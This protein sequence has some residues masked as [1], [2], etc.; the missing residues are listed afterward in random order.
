VRC[1][2]PTPSPDICLRGLNHYLSTVN[3][4]ELGQQGIRV[5][6]GPLL[7]HGSGSSRA[8]HTSK[9][10]AGSKT[11]QWEFGVGERDEYVLSLGHAGLALNSDDCHT[12]LIWYS[13]ARINA[14]STDTCCGNVGANNLRFRMDWPNKGQLGMEPCAAMAGTCVTSSV[15]S[16][17]L[18]LSKCQAN[19]AAQTWKY[20]AATKTISQSG[21]CFDS[22][23]A[24]D[25]P[26]TATNVWA[27]NLTGAAKAVVFLNAG[28]SVANITCDAACFARMVAVAPGVTHYQSRDLWAHTDNGTVVVAAGLSVMVEPSAVVMLKLTPMKQPAQ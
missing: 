1:H 11:Q 28:P 7:Q 16:N 18:T 25:V 10:V 14:N 21:R 24:P 3:Q 23:A 13:A 2:N 17:L 12:D 4:D 9:C 20:D 22:A 8:A 26:S 15:G 19:D 27:R 5:V 6:G